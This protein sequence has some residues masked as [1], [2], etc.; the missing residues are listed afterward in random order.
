MPTTMM[1]MTTT[2]MMTVTMMIIIMILMIITMINDD[3]DDNRNT[4]CPVISS[5]LTLEVLSL[6][7]CIFHSYALMIINK[8]TKCVLPVSQN[9]TAINTLTS[10]SWHYGY[11]MV[12]RN[13]SQVRAVLGC[14]KPILSYLSQPNINTRWICTKSITKC[15]IV[16]FSA[17]A[18]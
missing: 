12:I 13:I 7:P 16:V 2:T 14:L 4:F 8:I 18:L 10:L 6:T 9:V 17:V 1:T 3:H 5:I 15:S 11:S